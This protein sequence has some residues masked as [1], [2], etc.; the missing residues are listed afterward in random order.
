MKFMNFAGRF[1][2][3]RLM[4]F[5]CS[6]LPVSRFVCQY[7][8]LQRFNDGS[9]ELCARTLCHCTSHVSLQ[10]RFD[11]TSKCDVGGQSASARGQIQVCSYVIHVKALVHVAKYKYVVTSFM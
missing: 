3:E 6:F 5:A 8:Q 2:F 7:I 10:N 11:A 4:V 9:L 1:A